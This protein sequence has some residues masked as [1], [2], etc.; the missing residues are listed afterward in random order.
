MFYLFFWPDTQIVPATAKCVWMQAKVVF[1]KL[2]EQLWS[3]FEDKV[4]ELILFC[5]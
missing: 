4:Q 3:L 1:L 5:V 2:E